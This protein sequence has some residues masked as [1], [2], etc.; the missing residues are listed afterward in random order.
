MDKGKII[1]YAFLLVMGILMFLAV[2]KLMNLNKQEKELK[3][4]LTK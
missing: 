4:Q 2:K 1:F 3:A